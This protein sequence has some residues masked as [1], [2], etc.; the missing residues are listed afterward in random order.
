MIKR[1]LFDE[2][3]DILEVQETELSDDD[4]I[5]EALEPFLSDYQICVTH[6]VGTA[7]GCFL[8]RK[9]SLPL[10]ELRIMRDESGRF[11]LWNFVVFSR[12]CRIIWV[13]AS[14]PTVMRANSFPLT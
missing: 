6:A 5:E 2:N 4:R 14:T 10:S 11:L 9:K 12:L 13:Y 7:G 1:F 3:I 8:L